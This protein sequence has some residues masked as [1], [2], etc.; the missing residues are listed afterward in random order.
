MKKLTV[1]S[2]IP[3]QQKGKLLITKSSQKKEQIN[4]VEKK[5]VITQHDQTFNVILNKGETLLNTALMQEIP[6]DYKCKKGTCGR[7]HVHVNQGMEYL[8]AVNDQ[9]KKKLET[10]VEHGDRLACQATII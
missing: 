3:N 4:E 10:A 9:E 6:L 2:L 5:I 8:T 7:C 1:G